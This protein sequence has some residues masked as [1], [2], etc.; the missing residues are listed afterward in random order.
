MRIWV[1]SLSSLSRLRIWS[2]RELWCRSKTRLRSDVAM[3]VVQAGSCSSDLTASLGTS[4]CLRCG[5]KKRKKEKRKERKRNR[6]VLGVSS[7]LDGASKWGQSPPQAGISKGRAWVS[8]PPTASL[9]APEA[10][11]RPPCQSIG[12]GKPVGR[13]G[14]TSLRP[15]EQRH[16]REP[17]S[18]STPD[19]ELPGAAS[20]LTVRVGTAT[21]RGAQNPAAPAADP[22]E[23][24][25]L[26]PLEVGRGQSPAPGN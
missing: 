9:A 8:T 26:S 4:I 2:C 17:G 12:F 7:P 6:H 3:A 10:R 16:G 22:P 14:P 19:Q 20:D 13:A 24:P 25:S 18:P 23:L 15:D 5:P 1:R 11:P 21:A